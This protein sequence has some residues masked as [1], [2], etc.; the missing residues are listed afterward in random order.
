MAAAQRGRSDLGPGVGSSYSLDPV[1]H[2]ASQRTNADL[3]WIDP[4]I[5]RDVGVGVMQVICFTT[6]APTKTN[7]MLNP[8][9]TR[10]G[11]S[12]FP[13][14]TDWQGQT[15]GNVRLRLSAFAH[16]QRLQGHN[17]RVGASHDD[18]D[19]YKT[20]TYKTFPAAEWFAG[21]TGPV[22]EFRHSTTSRRSSSRT[23]HVYAQDEWNVVQDWTF[24]CRRA[25]RQLFRFGGT[26]NPRLA[27]VWDTPLDL[28]TSCCGAN[29]SA[30]RHF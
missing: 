28:T 30:P 9:G 7:L 27:L 12:Y 2:V 23:I 10:I 26:T 8:P 20:R 4:Q 25:P 22:Q 24:D 19:L 5:A 15:A 6:S 16:L 14:G 13:D 29:R 3:S 21:A 1:S 17:L 11:P 18:L